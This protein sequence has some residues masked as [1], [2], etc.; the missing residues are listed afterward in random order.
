MLDSFESRKEEIRGV[1][2]GGVVIFLVE[3]AR[4][5]RLEPGMRPQTFPWKDKS[6]SLRA[7][8]RSTTARKRSPKGGDSQSSNLLWSSN[9]QE[10]GSPKIPGRAPA[11][12]WAIW[13]NKLGWKEKRMDSRSL[14]GYR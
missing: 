8:H 2:P 5:E 12:F 11:R 6:T 1:S 4:R 9:P 10:R 3:L 7:T 14:L 13:R